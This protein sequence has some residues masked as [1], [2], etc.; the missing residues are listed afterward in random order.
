MRD[1]LLRITFRSLLD[2]SETG[3]E[4][5]VGLEK[6]RVESEKLSFSSGWKCS[7]E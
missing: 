6:T 2:E 7:A 5:K 4:S 3:E 1:F